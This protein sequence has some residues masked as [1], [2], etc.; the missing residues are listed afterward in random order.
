MHFIQISLSYRKDK[1][2][3]LLLVSW[4]SIGLWLVDYSWTCQFNQVWYD[5]VCLLK[6]KTWRGQNE[7]ILALL[8]GA[9]GWGSQ[10]TRLGVAKYNVIKKWVQSSLCSGQASGLKAS[11][12]IVYCVDMFKISSPGPKPPW[13][14]P[15]PTSS[16]IK[17]KNQIVP[18]GLS[19]SLNSLDQPSPV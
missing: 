12:L 10:I 1:H 18:R 7:L 4:R 6:N 14:C 17:F 13:L 3:V 5:I 8:S 2:A 9:G 15:N 11:S 19:L 16:P